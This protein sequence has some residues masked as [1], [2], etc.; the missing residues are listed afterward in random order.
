MNLAHYV[1]LYQKDRFDDLLSTADGNL[2]LFLRSMSRTEYLEKLAAKL[3]INIESIK[4]KDLLKLVFEAKPKMKSVISFIKDSYRESRAVR[5]SSESD[6]ISELYKVK[7][8]EWGG[9]H[10]NSLEKTIVNN[11]VK[12]I[13]SFDELGKKVDGE[14]LD[15]LRN[16]VISS[17]YNHWTSIIIEDIFK[18]HP[19]VL[20]AIGLVQK[21]DF[22]LEGYPFDLKVTYLPEGYIKFCRKQR[23][24]RPELTEAKRICRELGIGFDRL[25]VES[26][27]LPD[28]WSKI[29]DHPSSRAE[30]VLSELSATRRSILDD[31]I[32]DSSSLVRWLY[33]NQGERRFDPGS[34]IFLVLVN[35]GNYFESW[36]LKRSKELLTSE[37]TK[38]LDTFGSSPGKVLDFS[39]KG[40][41][42]K[43]RADAIII[44]HT[45]L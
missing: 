21:I 42:F 29:K 32:T 4:K 28:L 9:L 6:L 10:Q 24:L 38:Y 17:W 36:K 18:D 44:E 11:Y 33:E 34:R 20:P 13:R 23:N 41:S 25:M 43:T 5:L 27:L 26:R 1:S 12:R 40:Q 2:F 37:I 3:D 14:L 39:W 45:A 7:A 15:S 8:F 22:F 19:R 16:Y 35:V 31:C 30:E